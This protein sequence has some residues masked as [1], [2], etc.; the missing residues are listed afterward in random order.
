MASKFP[1]GI[2]IY[3]YIIYLAVPHLSCDMWDLVPR[4]GVKPKA[5]ALG[6]Q[7]C[8]PWTTSRVLQ[9]ELESKSDRTA[10]HFSF[11]MAELEQ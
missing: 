5:P 4:S 9:L 8:S 3:K 6:A 11:E 2:Y 7:S 10:P 1:A